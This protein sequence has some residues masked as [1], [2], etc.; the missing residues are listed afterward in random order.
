MGCR[1]NPKTPPT[2]FIILER[3]SNII[4]RENYFM[5]HQLEL[6]HRQNNGPSES[7]N[8][9]DVLDEMLDGPLINF[10]D[11]FRLFNVSDSK[12]G[13]GVVQEQTVLGISGPTVLEGKRLETR[14]HLLVQNN[15]NTNRIIGA[16]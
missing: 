10:L 3:P 5:N 15:E 4:Q 9:L 2:R 11:D 14:V 12:L 8:R 1:S 13:L 16:H 7:K 6:R